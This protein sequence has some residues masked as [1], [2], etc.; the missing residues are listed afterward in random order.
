MHLR[1]GKTVK[2]TLA[3]NQPKSKG[4][5]KRP[6]KLNLDLARAM[7]TKWPFP[8]KPKSLPAFD[9]EDPV[10]VKEGPFVLPARGIDPFLDA[11]LDRTP[12][13]P[14]YSREENHY[15]DC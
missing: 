12:T 14:T 10:W 2:S 4:I 7:Q 1:N 6:K 5:K 8:T 9:P 3:T 13:S 11:W 15:F